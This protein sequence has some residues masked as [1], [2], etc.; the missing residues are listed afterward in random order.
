M[1][2]PFSTGLQ[3]SVDPLRSESGG[4][5]T[6]HLLVAQWRGEERGKVFSVLTRLAGIA[7]LGAAL[8]IPGA[9]AA[10]FSVG[11]DAV[12]FDL[13]VRMLSPGYYF[14]VAA[15]LTP[16]LDWT[17][18]GAPDANRPGLR[19]YDVVTEI[20]GVLA[21]PAFTPTG[22]WVPAGSAAGSGNTSL[23]SAIHALSYVDVPRLWGR[24]SAEATYLIKFMAL[25]VDGAPEGTVQAD[26]S[27]NTPLPDSLPM[28]AAAVLGLGA[29]G[30]WRGRSKA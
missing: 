8:S 17:G 12:G 7:L 15:P 13:D 19:L 22:V 1:V 6:R 21:A 29:L 26:K 3:V 14:E 28:F 9:H 23:A 4:E 25:V 24:V 27:E 2:A 18:D 11:A 30:Y 20:E 10:T 16:E 5:S